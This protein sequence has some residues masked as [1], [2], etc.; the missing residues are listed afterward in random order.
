MLKLL[1]FNFFC[2][3]EQQ[4][5]LS[6]IDLYKT[7]LL[8]THINWTRADHTNFGTVDWFWNCLPLV[9]HLGSYDVSV[10]HTLS[11]LVIKTLA[12][13]DGP[14]WHSAWAI[15]QTHT[16]ALVL[17][18]TCNL[19]RALT[20]WSSQARHHCPVIACSQHMLHI[21]PAKLQIIL[22]FIAHSWVKCFKWT[23]YQ[24]KIWC[25]EVREYYISTA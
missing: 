13:L 17:L 8:T 21:S 15:I 14:R 23:D 9:W 18:E 10:V 1:T 20:S 19:L 24:Q 3:A 7:N 5:L 25:S 12:V 16:P 2:C 4:V 22:P 6:H 11:P